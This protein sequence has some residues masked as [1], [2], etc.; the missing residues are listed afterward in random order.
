MDERLPR[1]IRAIMFTDMV[2]FTQIMGQDEE[3]GLRLR[4]T[5]ELK[6]DLNGTILI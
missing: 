5:S 2:G 4:S 3:L 6:N 1:K